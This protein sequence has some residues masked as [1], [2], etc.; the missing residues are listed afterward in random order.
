MT[1]IG[2]IRFINLHLLWLFTVLTYDSVRI[3]VVLLEGEVWVRVS[4]YA[5]NREG[6]EEKKVIVVGYCKLKLTCMHVVD[7]R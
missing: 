4:I 1:I 6:G 3:S 7:Y 5:W 2:V